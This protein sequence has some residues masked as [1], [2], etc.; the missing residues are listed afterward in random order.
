MQIWQKL[1][2]YAL[3]KK[4]VKL[5]ANVRIIISSTILET[6]LIEPFFEKGVHG[7][8]PKQADDKLLI[9]TVMQVMKGEIVENKQITQNLKAINCKRA[10][11]NSAFHFDLTPKELDVLMQITEGKSNKIIAEELKMSER[12]VEFHRTNIYKKTNSN[13]IA[14]LVMLTIVARLL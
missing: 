6:K 4:I 2:S 1:N 13:S 9:E 14:D 8:I 10:L 11:E 12:T 7:F 3:L 5:C